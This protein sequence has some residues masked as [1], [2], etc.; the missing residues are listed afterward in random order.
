MEK[1]WNCV[2]V[3]ET[4][5]SDVYIQSRVGGGS[6]GERRMGKTIDDLK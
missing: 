5:E 3:K 4:P 1:A 2:S 6:L